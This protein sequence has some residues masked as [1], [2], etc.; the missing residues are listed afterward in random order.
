MLTKGHLILKI[1]F[2]FIVWVQGVHESKGITDDYIRLESL[3]RKVVSPY[4]GTNGLY[5]DGSSNPHCSTC[6]LGV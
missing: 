3:V 1:I 6:L 5:S 4:L 2:F